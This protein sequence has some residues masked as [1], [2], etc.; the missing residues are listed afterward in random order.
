MSIQ[1]Q[2]MSTSSSSSSS[3]SNQASLLQNVDLNGLASQI[4][5]V[6]QINKIGDALSNLTNQMAYL[7]KKVDSE[8]GESEKLFSS[9]NDPKVRDNQDANLTSSSTSNANRFIFPK[10]QDK[11]SK[12][13]RKKVR[14]QIE[15]DFKSRVSAS[16][17]T[18]YFGEL[19]SSSSSSSS[20]SNPA[21][22]LQNID[23]NGLSS[24]I[25]NVLQ[26]ISDS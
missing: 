19:S 23:L 3:L 6:L 9:P 16:D 21:G 14:G 26:R 4:A 10:L 17:F 13:L 12:N 2:P 1:T 22:Q 24:Q 7:H 11:D 5:N 8:F 18:E 15:K 25:A 20:L